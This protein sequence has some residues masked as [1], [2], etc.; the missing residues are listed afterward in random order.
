MKLVVNAPTGKGEVIE[1]GEGGGYFDQSRVVWDEREDGPVPAAMLVEIEAAN[2]PSLAD[3]KA[4]KK[5][6]VN[7]ECDLRMN[8]LVASYPAQEVATFAKQETE[9]RA[10]LANSAASTP[11][12]DA[13]AAN[14]GVPK[15]ELAARI[16]AKADAFAAYA[17]RVIGYRQ[18]LED[19][20][21]A[22]TEAT[23]GAIDPLAGWPS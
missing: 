23:L 8:A 10:F 16:V 12:I 4:A 13:L 15:A 11:L 5:I 2:A 20:I 1:I 21:D 9:A 3:L 17:G 7:K 6:E 19:Q 18:K 22:A 14:R